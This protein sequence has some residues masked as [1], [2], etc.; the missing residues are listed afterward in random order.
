MNADELAAA[1]R[2]IELVA[3]ALECDVAGCRRCL[4]ALTLDT[5]RLVAIDSRKALDALECARAE[6][7]EM[8]R[9]R[10]TS[11]EG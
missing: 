4:R 9:L 7:G 5:L 3:H 2:R 1:R 6:A 8:M 11:G 10:A